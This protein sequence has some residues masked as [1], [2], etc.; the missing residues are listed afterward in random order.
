MRFATFKQALAWLES[1]VDFEKVAPNRADVPT[2]QPVRDTLA[3]LAHPEEDYPTIHITGTNGKGTTTTLITTLL[4]EQGFSV[5][6]FLSPDLQRI[7][8]RIA[9]NGE[10]ISDAA[11]TNLLSR[12]ADVE[13]AIGIRL[14]RFE[15]LTVGAFLHFS[16][17]GVEVGVIEVGLGG[18]WD[19]TNVINGSVSVVTNVDLDH[20]AVLGPTVSHIARDKVGIFRGD[21]VAV[22]GTDD[23]V[24]AD[25]AQDRADDLGCPLVMRGR[26]FQLVSNDLSV[27]GRLVSFVTPRASYD[28]VQLNLHGIHQGA[29]AVVAVVAVEEFL[30]RALSHDVVASAFANVVMPGRMEVL[31]NYPLIVIDGAHNPAGVRAL[32]ATLDEA[33]HLVGERRV[34][35]GMLTGREIAD[36]LDPLLTLGVTEF[37]VCEPLSPRT[38]SAEIIAQYISERGGD[39]TVVTDPRDAL[40]YARNQS[41]PE[42]QIVIAG[43][44]YLVGDLRAALL[45]LPYQHR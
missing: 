18:T 30:D 20:T 32:A 14:T 1:H 22:L 7:N 33:F 13:D 16:D 24:V 23:L 40:R 45:A 39:V 31:E 38:Q 8:E 3:A 42:D 29:N 37:V 36:M 19:S 21:G 4:A 15:L 41:Q 17:M 2:L 9:V 5:G 6:T 10:P 25:I 26:D 44:L 43:S 27:G 35:L 11:F 34:V 28:E 12:L